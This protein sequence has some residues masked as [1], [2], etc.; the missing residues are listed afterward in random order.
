M[1]WAAPTALLDGF[2]AFLSDN[3]FL[4]Y[5]MSDVSN[6]AWIPTLFGVLQVIMQ[7]VRRHSRNAK[8]HK[9]PNLYFT[10]DCC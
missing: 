6:I 5:V 8:T 10:L 1:N 9:F 3:C 7:Q 2:I 4:S